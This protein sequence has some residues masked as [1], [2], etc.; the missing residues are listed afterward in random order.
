MTALVCHRFLKGM[1][2]SSS[3][4]L[5]T[6]WYILTR[7]YIFIQKGGIDTQLAKLDKC[8]NIFLHIESPMKK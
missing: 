1:C 6:R 2:Q 7:I 5:A 3:T 8:G 4:I